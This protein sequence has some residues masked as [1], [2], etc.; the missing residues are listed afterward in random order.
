MISKTLERALGELRAAEQKLRARY[1]DLTTQRKKAVH[2]LENKATIKGRI[3]AAVN[4]A[5]A[6]W[7]RD[8]ALIII[9]ALSAHKGKSLLP[10][11]PKDLS[12]LTL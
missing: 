4:T 8:N 5:G 2:A 6:A 3:A 11:L 10:V 12:R 7:R 1:S 9:G